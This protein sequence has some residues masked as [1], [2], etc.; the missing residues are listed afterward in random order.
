MG[1]KIYFPKNEDSGDDLPE[2]PDTE[3]FIKQFYRYGVGTLG[4]RGLP[5]AGRFHAALPFI[6]VVL[7]ANARLLYDIFMA[8]ASGM[9]E[10]AKEEREEREAKRRR[11]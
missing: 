2:H 10:A 5:D 9:N 4:D 7:E 3:F 11:P 1:Q 8:A 6:G